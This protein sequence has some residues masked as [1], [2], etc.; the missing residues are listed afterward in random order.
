M[1]KLR[2]ASLSCWTWAQKQALK[3]LLAIQPC[4]CWLVGFT[5]AA[6]GKLLQPQHNQQQQFEEWQAVTKQPAIAPSLQS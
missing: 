4:M 3:M 2:S 5:T 6:A 1:V